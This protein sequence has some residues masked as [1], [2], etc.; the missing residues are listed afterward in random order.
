MCGIW[1]L[2]DNNDKKIDVGVGDVPIIHE[3]PGLK[4]MTD[5]WKQ[6][7]KYFLNKYNLFLNKTLTV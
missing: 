5:D 1:A 4:E 7:Q 2:I 3:S 6:G